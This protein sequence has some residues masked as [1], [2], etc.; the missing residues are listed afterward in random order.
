MIKVL[1]ENSAHHAF[2][3]IQTLILHE[4]PKL[5]RKKQQILRQKTQIENSMN[6]KE[7]SLISKTDEKVL[8]VTGWQ[9]KT[10]IQRV[11]DSENFWNQQ[12]LMKI[13]TK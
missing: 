11:S 4:I 9:K 10:K 7:N 2:M 3:K 8:P 1:V 13:T 12:F 5:W 6:L